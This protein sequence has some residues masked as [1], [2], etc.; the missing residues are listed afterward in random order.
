MIWSKPIACSFAVL[1]AAGCVKRSLPHDRVL[2]LEGTVSAAAAIGAG[3][4]ER[5]AEHLALA[6][7]QIE[8]ARKLARDGELGEA[9]LV[10]E[11]AQADAELA[12]MITRAEKA[13]TE[14]RE[15]LEQDHEVSSR[16]P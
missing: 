15:V 5:A 3:K 12:I 4:D 2:V 14:A 16:A 1:A 8:R 7:R 9:R 11:G 6:R 10:L 13:R